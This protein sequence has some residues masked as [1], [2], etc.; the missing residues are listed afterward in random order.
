MAST[1]PC[2]ILIHA[3][4]GNTVLH[5]QID[6]P[7]R[8]TPV[9]SG[10]SKRRKPETLGAPW[11]LFQVCSTWR[12]IAL[13]D[14]PLWSTIPVASASL[15]RNL[16]YLDAQIE[17]AGTAPLDILFRFTGD[18]DTHSPRTLDW[19][20]F[21]KLVERRQQWRSLHLEFIWA[22]PPP[23]SFT[24]HAGRDRIQREEY[25]R[26]WETVF[27]NAHNTPSPF[28]SLSSW[29]GLAS[30]KASFQ[31]S[32]THLENLS[33]AIN[34]VECDIDFGY[35]LAHAARRSLRSTTSTLFLPHVIAPA[36]LDLHVHGGD[37]DPI[38][39]FLYLFKCATTLTSLTLFMCD[40]PASQVLGIFRETPALTTLAVD[41][42]GPSTETALLLATLTVPSS[43]QDIICPRLTSLSW[44]DRNDTIDRKAFM[45]M[46]E[47]RWRTAPRLCFVGLY[48][49]CIRIKT[50]G[51]RLRALAEEGLDVVLSGEREESSAYVDDEVT[52]ALRG[53]SVRLGMEKRLTRKER[54][55]GMSMPYW[56]TLR[57]R[58]VSRAMTTCSDDPT[59]EPP[60]L[61]L[62]APPTLPRPPPPLLPY[63]AERC[64]CCVGLFERC[65][66]RRSTSGSAASPTGTSGASAAW[67][68]SGAAVV[69]AV[70]AVAA[71]LAL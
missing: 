1:L 26:E 69:A 36:L 59:A 45:D 49:G 28:V 40:A 23:E 67:G 12:I 50:A 7:P 57:M 19:K 41:F 33:G 42:L 25:D 61:P 5:L 65:C 29:E 54:R 51:L 56:S 37:L 38:L 43:E 66:R 68:F 53:E 14:P 18:E 2:P 62:A 39:P 6:R 44:G 63:R 31:Y 30:Y 20:V 58:L 17:R 47:S 4:P 55:L 27:A 8:S 32:S 15:P 10:K 9:S 52:G 16:Q 21:D 46:V 24:T 11:S 64:I 35:H 70:A 22:Y 48:L 34:L 3:L 71:V 60:P 13:T